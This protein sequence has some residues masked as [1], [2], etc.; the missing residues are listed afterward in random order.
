[1]AIGVTVAAEAEKKAAMDRAAALITVAQAE[2]DQTRIGAEGAATAERL[3]ADAAERT[4]EVQ[5]AGQRALNGAANILSAEQVARQVRF[6]IMAA[7]RRSIQEGRKA[8]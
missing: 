6:A 7:L 3:R 5:S 1:M 4:Y 8:G 2:A